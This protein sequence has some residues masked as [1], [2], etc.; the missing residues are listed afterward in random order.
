MVNHRNNLADEIEKV[1]YQNVDYIL[2]LNDTDGHWK[3]IT[4]AIKPQGI[5]CS[6]VENKQPLEMKT[7]KSKSV[8]F[9][10]EFMFTRSMYQTEDMAEQ[11]HLLNELSQ[12]IEAGVIITTCNDI[13]KPINA[14]NLRDVHQRLEQ[15]RSI[16]KIVLSEWN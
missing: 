13:V 11:S 3:G 9:V 10:W 12:L 14:K 7:L 2:C 8:A 6:I 16:G 15:G 1:G 5:I 4:K